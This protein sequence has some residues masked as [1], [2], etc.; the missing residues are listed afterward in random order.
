MTVPS[1]AAIEARRQLDA[2]ID[3]D[4]RGSTEETREYRKRCWIR[5]RRCCGFDDPPPADSAP[6]LEAAQ[7]AVDEAV[8]V[9]SNHPNDVTFRVLM[10]ARKHRNEIRQRLEEEMAR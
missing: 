9:Y 5:W 10:G 2:A 4:H 3:A 7:A 1:P 6:T 8:R